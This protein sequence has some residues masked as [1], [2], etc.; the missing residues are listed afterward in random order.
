MI[1]DKIIGMMPVLLD[2][3]VDVI[4]IFFWTVID[5]YKRQFTHLRTHS[6][7]N[8]RIGLKAGLTDGRSDDRNRRFPAC[9]ERHHF[10]DRLTR[11]FLRCTAPARMTDRT[12][13]GGRIVE[14]CYHTVRVKDVYKRQL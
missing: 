7:R 3:T 8:I 4:K 13:C 11:D 12:H 6:V 14:Q 10:L 5:V 1:F 9:A 2:G